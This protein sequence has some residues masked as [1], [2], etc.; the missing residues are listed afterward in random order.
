MS[1]VTHQDKIDR[2]QRFYILL[3]FLVLHQRPKTDGIRW[4]LEAISA[5]LK[6]LSQDN[7]SVALR[8]LQEAG[9]VTRVGCE[10]FRTSEGILAYQQETKS[11]TMQVGGLDD[12]RNEVLTGA[13]VENDRLVPTKIMSAA[14]PGNSE[15]FRFRNV[16][17][18]EQLRRCARNERISEI[19]V[20]N[21]VSLEDCR[22]MLETEE[23][24]RCSK[25][26]KY[27]R[28]HADSR[29]GHRWQSSCI[30]CR[31]LNRK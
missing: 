29:P 19:A 25:C 9:Y 10:W 31:K 16:V 7:I 5:N 22:N 2:K 4:D 21:G 23:I 18:Y 8:D 28:H 14:L 6:S 24:H 3:Q 20:S 17:E 13:R 15:H 12:Y 11:V 30:A 1:K 26:G 27:N